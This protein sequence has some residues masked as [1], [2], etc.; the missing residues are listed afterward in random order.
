M[1]RIVFCRRREKLDQTRACQSRGAKRTRWRRL[2]NCGEDKVHTQRQG[3]GDD[4]MTFGDAK[5]FLAAQ[6]APQTPARHR[7]PSSC[8]PKLP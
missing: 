7:E 1:G 2:T 3:D 5:A 6:F 8:L 4:R